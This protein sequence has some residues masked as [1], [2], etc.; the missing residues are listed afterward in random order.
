MNNFSINALT[1]TLAAGDDLPV[2][3][4]GDYVRF[5]TGSSGLLISVNNGSY[6]PFEEGV[7]MQGPAGEGWF[8]RLSVRNTNVSAETFKI[9]YGIGNY[10]I[11]GKVTIADPNFSLTTQDKADIRGPAETV[12]RVFDRLTNASATYASL[13]SFY[14]INTGATDITADGKT[15]QPGDEWGEEV[16]GRYDRFSS[17][18][19]NATGG[20]AI[21]T[22]TI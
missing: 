2:N 8:Q 6:V 21:V 14:I 10:N 4:A 11:I 15:L 7:I 12:G 18:I 20:S 17:F 1:R 16:R 9:V 5:V 19:V 22:G 13:R 3:C